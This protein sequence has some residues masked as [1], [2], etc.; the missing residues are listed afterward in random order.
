MSNQPTPHPHNTPQ[1][2]A[3][4]YAA[5]A[6][7]GA[8]KP[9]APVPPANYGIPAENEPARTA[10]S[11]RRKRR[12]RRQAA[13]P[14]FFGK[15]VGIFI[16]LAFVTLILNIVLYTC[17]ALWESSATFGANTPSYV[18]DMV[19]QSLTPA[20]GEASNKTNNAAES[21]A[22]DP[23]PQ[24][25]PET[26]GET[27]APESTPATQTAV[28]PSDTFAISPEAARALDAMQAWCM[29]LDENGTA[30]WQRN[31]PQDAA[32]SYTN[33][34]IAAFSRLGYLGSYPCFV[35]NADAGLLVVCTPKD[36]YFPTSLY[37]PLSTVL[38]L[39]V[40]ALALFLMNAAIFF[41]AYVVS[42]RRVLKSV[43]PVLDALDNLSC[44]KP[45]HVNAH[46]SLHD[47]GES[48][49]AASAAM[50]RKDEARKRWVNG[51]SHDIRTPLAISMGTAERLAE[52]AQMPEEAR[53]A[54][55]VIVR[56]N[57][58]MRDFV[59][60]LNIASRL[61]YD[62]QPLDVASVRPAALARQIAVDRL[63][64]GLDEH[65]SIEVS[66]TPQ[67]ESAHL[68][69][70]ERLIARA[71]HNLMEN[72]LRHNENGCDILISLD[73]GEGT[74]DMQVSDNGSGVSEATCARLNEEAQALKRAHATTEEPR[75]GLPVP[76]PF[77]ETY[78]V[79]NPQARPAAPDARATAAAM[80][81]TGT[82]S[83][84]CETA[85]TQATASQP[86]LQPKT[87]SG[88]NDHG[89]GLS[90]VTRIV[91]AHGGTIE[92]APTAQDGF[93]ATM[94]LPLA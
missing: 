40:Y 93:S 51:V 32:T 87:L 26:E 3:G 52:N 30:I 68:R 19:A 64:A 7:R 53:E 81:T 42:K 92:F 66:A 29:L 41:C 11:E 23:A 39:P 78:V 65:Y 27:P 75:P 86:S 76:P 48:V 22:A 71:L 4:P 2:P 25:A 58:R 56:Q 72:A 28:V 13:A 35:W 83:P 12:A 33:G 44:G 47:I 61:E 77:Y 70:D 55:R 16:L 67:A 6:A 14:L 17:V 59:A 34:E 8:H 9:G 36:S 89:L 57:E 50:L 54:A 21:E 20:H 90:L 60:D 79:R 18:T 38:R 88:F 84:Y 31:M 5:P 10:A 46:G 62:M 80:P 82:P 74:L 1:P 63:N 43:E 15:Q 85:E 69:A 37:L 45:A 49:N 24:S 73:C 94:H 91:L